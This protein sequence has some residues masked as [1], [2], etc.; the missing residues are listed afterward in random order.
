MHTTGTRRLAV[1]LVI[2]AAVLRAGA[3]AEPTVTIEK[4]KPRTVTGGS[5]GI[6]SGDTF[7]GT[8]GPSTLPTLAFVIGPGS[9]MAD[10][11]H[12]N[13][14]KYTGPG[15]YANVIVAVYL[16]KTALE[17]SYGGLGT[18]VINGDGRTGTFTLNNGTA[19]GRFDCG[20]VPSA[21]PARPAR[22]R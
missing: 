12:A 15:K 13:K 19:S 9:A 21:S 18:V 7:S 6:P 5:C 20:A 1:S 11:M 4:P 17:D 8:F 2:V 16:G 22:S 10:Q 3:A 14:A